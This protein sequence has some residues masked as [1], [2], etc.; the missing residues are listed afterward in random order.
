MAT[1]RGLINAISVSRQRGTPKANV[2]Q[3]D[4]EADFGIVGDAHAGR[5]HRQVSLLGVE[6]INKLR[7]KGVKVSP[8]DFAENI[9]IEGLPVKSLKLGSK[10]RICGQ[11]ELEVT[12]LGKR[13]HRRC[14]IFDRLGECI[15]PRD[16]VFA[17]VT[18]P[19]RIKVGDIIEVVD[20]KSGDTDSQ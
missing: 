14:G 13:C 18:T 8:G 3:A 7:E 20:D 5:G 6:S 11:V 17:R 2:A 12:Q 1:T 19:G 10:L 16:G 4:L 9:T 15:M